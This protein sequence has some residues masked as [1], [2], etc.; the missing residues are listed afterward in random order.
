MRV[1]RRDLMISSSSLLVA[2]PGLANAVPGLRLLRQGDAV[3]VLLDGAPPWMLAPGHLQTGA[4]VTTDGQETIWVRAPLRAGHGADLTLR[5]SNTGSEVQLGA[6]IRGWPATGTCPGVSLAAFLQGRAFL[7]MPVPGSARRAMVPE[8]V[9]ESV[10]VPGSVRLRLHRAASQG[11]GV[12]LRAS[13]RPFRL[14]GGFECRLLEVCQASGAVPDWRATAL[15]ISLPRTMTLGSNGRQVITL[16]LP[17]SS[18][19]VVAGT[20]AVTHVVGRLALQVATG[21]LREGPVVA[22]EARFSD[23]GN[24]ARTDLKLFDGHW[25]LQTRHAAF[26]ASGTG[27]TARVVRSGTRLGTLDLPVRLHDAG[28]GVAGAEYSR[29]DFHGAEACLQLPGLA[30]RSGAIPIPLGGATTLSL[31]LDKA[32]L[33]LARSADLMSLALRFRLV[34]L[35]LGAARPALRLTPAP[36]PEGNQEAETP[37]LVADFPP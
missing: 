21:A 22:A 5:F 16:D 9:G 25:T 13:A 34:T 17:A 29:L 20:P 7:E 35:E 15:D 19:V 4:T 36:K 14:P 18:K 23:A 10:I 8:V 3:F 27:L 26:G 2:R 31:P 12:A 11:L 28:I 24:E 1:T 37:L 30:G 33:R 32:R 6:D